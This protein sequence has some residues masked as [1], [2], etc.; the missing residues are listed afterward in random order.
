MASGEARWY[1]CNGFSREVGSCIITKKE[2]ECNLLSNQRLPA[3][4]PLSLLILTVKYLS[5]L[6]PD[7]WEEPQ[8]SS[9]SLCSAPFLPI[10]LYKHNRQIAGIK[11]SCSRSSIKRRSKDIFYYPCPCLK[12]DNG[13]LISYMFSFTNS[14]EQGFLLFN[15]AFFHINLNQEDVPTSCCK[16]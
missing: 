8:F 7:N 4:L 9:F 3:P 12:G 1:C 14:R 13:R 5:L 16:F 6:R 15:L 2:I 10:H 11:P